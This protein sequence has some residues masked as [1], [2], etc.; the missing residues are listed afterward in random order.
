MID[1]LRALATAAGLLLPI[2]ILTVIVSRLAVNRGEA[3]MH[4]GELAPDVV[5]SVDEPKAAKTAKAGLMPGRDPSVLEILILS[6]MVFM[7]MMGV[8]LGMSVLG[9]MR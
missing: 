1:V 2:V 6:L 7:L 4:P 5:S 9:Q 8:F 3:A